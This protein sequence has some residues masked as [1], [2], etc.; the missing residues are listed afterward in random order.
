MKH[1]TEDIFNEAMNGLDP[2]LVAEHISKR[3]EL[4]SNKTRPART[5]RLRRAAIA[6][7]AAAAIAAGAAGAVFI[8]NR[9]PE[10]GVVS[11][12][13]AGEAEFV[14]D[15]KYISKKEEYD[16]IAI[17]KLALYVEDP[18]LAGS[19]ESIDISSMTREELFE[20]YRSREIKEQAPGY[21][22]PEENEFVDYVTE[23]GLKCKIKPRELLVALSVVP[24]ID[25]DDEGN[26]YFYGIRVDSFET[27]Y[28]SVYIFEQGKSD[29][30]ICCVT[31]SSADDAELAL[32]TWNAKE[33][34]LTAEYNYY[35]K[36]SD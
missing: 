31:L 19:D 23:K 34:V 35:I 2:A 3:E 36:V 20:H 21:V 4:E 12:G 16:S 6:A 13:S 14:S 11:E 22:K 24:Q 9:A 30:V 32:Q 25:K 1:I 28:G 17:Q 15:R 33:E 27:A 10:P 26:L 18:G 7:V 8:A 5:Y 29:R